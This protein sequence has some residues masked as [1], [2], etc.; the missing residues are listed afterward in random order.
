MLGIVQSRETV[1]NLEARPYHCKFQSIQS[2][3]HHSFLVSIKWHTHNT[4][5]IN[6]RVRDSIL[7]ANRFN[8]HLVKLYRLT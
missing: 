7:C 8:V 6:Q 5:L 3:S 1:V 4:H 2:I